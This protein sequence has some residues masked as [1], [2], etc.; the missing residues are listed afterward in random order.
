MLYIYAHFSPMN[1]SINIENEK[2]TR[3]KP[4]LSVGRIVGEILA[5]TATGFAVALPVIKLF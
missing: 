5:G 2:Q 1:K 3:Q 4:P